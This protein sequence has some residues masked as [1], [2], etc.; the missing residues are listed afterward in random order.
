M[1]KTFNDLRVRYS[2]ASMPMKFIYINV[3]VFVVVK[4]V[5]LLFILMGMSPDIFMSYLELPSM[6]SVIAVQPWTVVTYMFLHFDI[7][8]IL[9]NMLW[10]YWFG[11]LFMQM[12]N[13]R[14]F[15]GLYLLGGIGGAVLFV[16]AYNL[17]PYFSGQYGMLLGAS[18][19]I[20]AVV[21]ATAMRA[22]DYK[23][24]LL[25]V[26]AV[27]LKWVAIIT[28]FIDFISIDT[29]NAGG[30]IAHIGGA[31]VGVAFGYAARRG[32]D[33]TAP[34]NGFI[35]S[36]VNFFRRLQGVKIA[37][38]RKRKAS[39]GEPIFNNNAPKTPRQDGSEPRMSATD[40]AD[41]D[42]ILAKIKQS[43][44][45]SLTAAEKKRLFEV[46]SSGNMRDK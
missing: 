19:S 31:A 21:T 13:A 42:V 18:A 30:H 25:L 40:E 43:G 46:S 15:V 7:L 37:G 44:Y 10:L 32:K 23:L 16:L 35:D 24:N 3:A 9:F 34:I 17:L 6:L 39:W 26:G 20:L 41:L 45:A 5:A 1:G 8:H 36:M 12:F 14:Q 4:V 28:I 33:L 2:L 29:G 22:P 11:V 27:S 38:R